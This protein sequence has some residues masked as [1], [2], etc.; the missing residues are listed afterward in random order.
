[1]RSKAKLPVKLLRVAGKKI[2]P[3]RLQ[4]GMIQDRRKHPFSDPLPSMRRRNDDIAKV[5]EGRAICDDTSETDLLSG[6]EKTEI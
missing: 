3:T 4:L 6:M 1:M 5:T 2:D